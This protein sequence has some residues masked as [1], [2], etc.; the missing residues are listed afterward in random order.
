MKALYSRKELKGNPFVGG[1]IHVPLQRYLHRFLNERKKISKMKFHEKDFLFEAMLCLYDSGGGKAFDLFHI[2]EAEEFLFY[3]IILIH[4]NNKMVFEGVIPVADGRCLDSQE[5]KRN[6]SYFYRYLPVWRKRIE[7]G[8]GAYLSIIKPEIKRKLQDWREYA[9]Q[10]DISPYSLKQKEI[11]IYACF[12][13]IYYNAKMYFD[14]LPKPYVMKK[15]CDFDV[16]FN[17]Y[18]YIHIYSRHYIP[19]MNQDIGLSTNP[20]LPEVDID[21]LPLSILMLIEK[22]SKVCPLS[23]FTE[24]CL[25]SYKGDKYILW[26]KYKLLNETKDYGFEVRSFYKCISE[27]DLEKFENYDY[28]TEGEVERCKMKYNT[29]LTI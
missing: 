2:P 3:W 6:K 25:F 23:S 5:K 15:I 19:N 21:E 29:I 16:V 13:N 9:V 28:D 27:S 10:K 8:E 4:S 11:F 1:E 7:S 20:D 22:Y 26:L 18:S 24:Y 14:E 17:V 12:F